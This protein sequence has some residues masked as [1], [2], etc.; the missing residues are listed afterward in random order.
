MMCPPISSVQ[1]RAR[2]LS[3][4]SKWISKATTGVRCR[5][6]L[7]CH[8]RGDRV[9]AVAAQCDLNQTGVRF[10]GERAGCLLVELVR[11]EH[12]QDSA[13]RAGR[14]ERGA[15]SG[16]VEYRHVEQVPGSAAGLN[17]PE[18]NRRRRRARNEQD[19]RGNPARLMRIAY[20]VGNHDR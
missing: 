18:I 20:S 12:D 9:D 7:D 4:A 6:C 8:G 1:V 17:W 10:D 16:S 5:R 19:S 11:L 3:V 2:S 15:G 14:A 13:V